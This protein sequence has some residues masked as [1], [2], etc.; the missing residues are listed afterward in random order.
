V[1]G[2]RGV[3]R[4]RGYRAAGSVLRG[5]VPATRAPPTGEDGLIAA[6]SGAPTWPREVL[7]ERGTEATTALCR[8]PDR[9]TQRT[10]GRHH[11]ERRP[12]PAALAQAR[13]V[14]QPRPARA[15]QPRHRSYAQSARHEASHCPATA[16][17][18]PAFRL[19]PRPRRRY[20][21]AGR[22]GAGAP[23]EPGPGA[24]RSRSGTR[25]R[26]PRPP[27]AAAVSQPRRRRCRTSRP[28]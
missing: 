5:H 23:G 17:R 2:V 19:R 25:P 1:H 16:K 12:S 4:G 7:V 11:A 14:V 18:A 22:R 27:T 24:H 8:Q 20:A 13:P 3:H 15:P 26:P 28:R 10:A 21:T 9:C 6:G